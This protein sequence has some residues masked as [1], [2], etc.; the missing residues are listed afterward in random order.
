[1]TSALP[2]AQLSHA[3]HQACLHAF[4]LS[5]SCLECASFA[6]L[7][8]DLIGGEIGFLPYPYGVA[9]SLLPYNLLTFILYP[10]QLTM[11][12]IPPPSLS[13]PFP[14]PYSLAPSCQF[15]SNQRNIHQ[16]RRIRKRCTVVRA[17]FH[18]TNPIH[19][20]LCIKLVFATSAQFSH[21]VA[22]HAM[23]IIIS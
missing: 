10:P 14:T 18:D 21:F 9:T 6:H 1:M 4:L 3:K 13:S 8:D 12:I 5:Q 7:A 17:F 2:Y 20:S 22:S 16:G 11:C 19:S 23:L 15:S